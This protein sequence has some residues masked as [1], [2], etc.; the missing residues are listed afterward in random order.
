MNFTFA[1]AIVCYALLACV[2]TDLS[3][4]KR[5]TLIALAVS[6]ADGMLFLA[7]ERFPAIAVATMQL[8]SGVE[9][10]TDAGVLGK[11]ALD[12]STSRMVAGMQLGKTLGVAALTLFVPLSLF[13]PLRFGRFFLFTTAMLLVLLSGFRS[14]LGMFAIL[15]VVNSLIHRR[16]FD[17]VIAAMV[18]PLLLALV[19]VSGQVR[20][21]PFG[22][23]RVLSVL[24]IDVEVGAREDGEK[25][26]EWR[27]EMWQ[28][29]L[30]TDRYIHNKLLGDGFG[31][32]ADE[33]R[34]AMD[35][36]FGAA[37]S[38]QGADI[39]MARGSFHGFHVETIRFTGIVGLIAALI[40][41]GIFFSVAWQLIQYFRH[42][43]E[44]KYVL[45]LCIPFLIHPFYYMLV[46]GSYKSGFPIILIS[47]GMLKLLDNIRRDE[48]AAARIT[49][50]V[51]STSR[52]PNSALNPVLERSR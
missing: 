5:V 26:S 43:P 39:M 23:Q 49:E 20:Q 52:R 36:V 17:I 14:I 50:P 15:F 30:F 7:S 4:F 16:Y 51:S 10:I 42:R 40:S 25:S 31:F 33:Q 28:R 1:F 37:R 48:L 12:L 2:R 27:F 41:M 21:L 9:F 35:A 32:R 8:Y 29:A 18:A 11:D 47:A 24:P 19:I 46:F 34:V 44:W 45:Y 38:Q 22:A 6:I 3:M 13:N